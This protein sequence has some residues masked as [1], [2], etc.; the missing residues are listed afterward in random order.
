[1]VIDMKV[2]EKLINMKEKEF[3]IIVVRVGMKV[4]SEMD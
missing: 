3:I 2:I 4:I 1:M